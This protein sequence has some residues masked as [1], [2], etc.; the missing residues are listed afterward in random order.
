M[1][2]R[3][4]LMIIIVSLC[5]VTLVAAPASAAPK[6]GGGK[7]AAKENGGG[8][9]AKGPKELKQ[10]KAG[11][12]TKEGHLKP[13]KAKG[14]KGGGKGAGG[15]SKEDQVTIRDFLLKNYQQNCPP[16]LAKKDNGCLPSGQARKYSIGQKLPVGVLTQAVSP[17]L[18]YLLHTPPGHRYVMVDQDVLLIENLNKIVVGAVTLA[19]AL[20]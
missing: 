20:K 15:I 2:L 16:G 10:P 9:K 1:K 14:G 11:E 7:G 19:A 4:A 18:L 17:G 13:L 6:E 5:A 12:F 3:A 8:G